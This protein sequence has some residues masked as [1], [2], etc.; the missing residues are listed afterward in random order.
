MPLQIRVVEVNAEMGGGTLPGSVIKS[1][2]LELTSE[3][4]LPDELAQRLRNTTPPVI[5]YI[6]R[7]KYRLD[8]RTIFPEQDEIVIRA[9]RKCLTTPA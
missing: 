1:V 2:A 8:L 4:L 6:V 9:L 7:R 5:G 3:S